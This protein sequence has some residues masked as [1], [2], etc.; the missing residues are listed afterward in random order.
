MIRA[1]K[2]FFLFVFCFSANS[3]TY[4]QTQKADSLKKLL[5]EQKTDTAKCL[6][7]NDIVRAYLAVSD[8]ENALDY[9]QQQLE[10]SEK[11]NFKRGEMNAN[12]NIGLIYFYR[13][14]FPK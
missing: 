13:G 9:T 6:L 4:S 3:I 14:N 1:C 10:L 2:I 8:F 5:P 7:L 12:N 11:L